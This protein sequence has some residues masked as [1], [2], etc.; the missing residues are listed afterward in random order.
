MNFAYN[1]KRT[2]STSSKLVPVKV[3]ANSDK[4]K[5]LIITENTGR[6]GIYKW[7]HI[8][9]G[10]SYI[11]SSSKLNIRLR[12]YFNFNHISYPKRNMVIYKALLKYGYAAFRLEILEYCSPEVLLEREQFYFD[13]LNPEY[14][15]LKIAG[16]PLGYRHSE[17]AKKLI[18]IA[19]K[20]REVLES[21]RDLKREALLG[22]VFDQERVDKMRLSNILRKSV[23]VTNKETGE[24]I[25]FSSM[26]EAGK[27]LG[28]SRV[29]VSKYLLNNIP[30]KNYLIS[31]K[32]INKEIPDISTTKKISQQPLLLTNIETGDT[33]NFSSITEAAKFLDVSRG[34]LW[35]LF[36]NG[37]ENGTLKGYTISKLEVSK[38]I[39]NRKTNNIE[40]TDTLTN[41]VTVYY[42]YTEASKALGV[43]PATFSTYFSRNSTNLF[44]KRY[45]LK[46]V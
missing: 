43:A 41:E 6:S 4:E 9:Y 5:E 2:F 23:I 24:I 29:T 19:S 27:Y 34:R 32:K 33:K 36:N 25:E 3:Y 40:V 37:V 46:L 44:R 28:I 45:I 13:L 30:Y 17:A 39:I 38:G 31:A 1:S 16:S 8:E 22:K 18:S 35:Y 42:S 26:T 7:V 10:K 15:I 20:D 11:G 14:N 12:Q 21:T